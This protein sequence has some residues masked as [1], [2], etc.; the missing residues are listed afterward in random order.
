MHWTFKEKVLWIEV[1]CGC[2]GEANVTEWFTACL[3]SKSEWIFISID[4]IENI[5]LC[6]IRNG[7]K[8]QLNVS[9]NFLS[10]YL[11]VIGIAVDET[12]R[13]SNE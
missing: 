12:N 5:A 6:N 11:I 7:K 2:G 8:I 13:R 1:V 4:E 9:F 10:Q 3:F